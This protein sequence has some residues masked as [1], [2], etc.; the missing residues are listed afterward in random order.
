VLYLFIQI[1]FNIIIMIVFGFNRINF[2]ELFFL[3]LMILLIRIHICNLIIN[4]KLLIIHFI[5]IKIL[6]FIFI[7]LILLFALRLFLLIVI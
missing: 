4:K 6:F 2:H 5:F 1:L 7:L 3:F